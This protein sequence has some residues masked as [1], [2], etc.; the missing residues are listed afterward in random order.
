MAIRALA[1][2]LSPLE[3]PLQGGPSVF[4]GR[5]V[6]LNAGAR[7]SAA[8]LLPFNRMEAGVSFAVGILPAMLGAAGCDNRARGAGWFCTRRGLR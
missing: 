3:G 2:E 1:D 7:A 5:A 6:P 4:W 8:N